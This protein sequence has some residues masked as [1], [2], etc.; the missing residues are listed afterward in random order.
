LECSILF[1]DNSPPEVPTIVLLEVV[2]TAEDEE[3]D[4]GI[5]EGLFPC[6]LLLDVAIAADAAATITAAAEEEDDD[7]VLLLLI[8]EVGG[9]IWSCVDDEE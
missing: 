8:P 2:D 9:C 3:E 6:C 5:A 4:E 7:E 1:T